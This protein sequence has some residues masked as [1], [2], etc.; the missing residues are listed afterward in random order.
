MN[1]ITPPIISPIKALR[2][3]MRDPMRNPKPLLAPTESPFLSTVLHCNRERCRRDS[4]RG[5]VLRVPRV[6][7][8]CTLLPLEQSPQCAIVSRSL[9]RDCH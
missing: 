3:P 9:G 6:R 1:P 2:S 8:E 5:A 7:H 4:A